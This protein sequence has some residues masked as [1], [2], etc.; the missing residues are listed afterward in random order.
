MDSY[1]L[2]FNQCILG[3]FGTNAQTMIL[4]TIEVHKLEVVSNRIDKIV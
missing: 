1:W 3:Y 2:S 4:L